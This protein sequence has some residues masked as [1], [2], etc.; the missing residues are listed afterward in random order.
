MRRSRLILPPSMRTLVTARLKPPRRMDL[1]LCKCAGSPAGR[2]GNEERHYGF[3]HS[4]DLWQQLDVSNVKQ[5][6][7][8]CRK[9]FESLNPCCW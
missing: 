3:R 6:L 5:T 7:Q 9:C 1:R 2:N 4:V 8:S